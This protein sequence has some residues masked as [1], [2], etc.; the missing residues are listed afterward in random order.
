[1]TAVLSALPALRV[2]NVVKRFGGLAAV[3]DISFTIEAEHIV[4]IIGPNGSG[5]STL[6][7]LITGIAPATSGSVSLGDRMI[8]RSK[9]DQIFRHGLGR[10]FQNTRLFGQLTVLENMTI[11]AR[12]RG[13][14]ARAAHEHVVA[15]ELTTLANE[16]CR[17]LSY[18]D[19]KL[20]ELSMCLIGDAH[21]VILDEPL[22]GVHESVVKQIGQLI[23]ERS[24]QSRFVIVEHNVAFMMGICERIIVM[25]HGR[26]IADGTPAEV[27]N[28]PAVE[29]A[30]FGTASVRE[31]VHEGEA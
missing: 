22:A 17:N 24:K 4:G 25:D 29:E 26:V 6:C 9:P 1:M 27:R 5:K 12:G 20:V 28:D 13:L 18:G 15:M 11:A 14:S 21:T 7:N 8:T 31:A 3:N 19:Q 10:T 16:E 30:Y 2:T 23:V